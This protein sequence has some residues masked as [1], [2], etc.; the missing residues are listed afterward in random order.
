[1]DPE[2]AHKGVRRAF[3]PRGQP[4]ARTPVEEAAVEG[5]VEY[6]EGQKK[7]EVVGEAAITVACAILTMVLLKRVYPIRF[8]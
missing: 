2:S 5:S 3:L 7:A 6:Q 4:F 8:V 1:M